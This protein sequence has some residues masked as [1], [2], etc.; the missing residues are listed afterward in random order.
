MAQRQR[1]GRVVFHDASLHVWE[2]GLGLCNGHHE[3]NEWERSFKREVFKR[4]IQQL[5]RMGWNA[6]PWDK[7]EQY[8]CIGDN[9]RTC[10]KGDLHGELALCGRHIEFN[11]WQSV[12]TPNRPDYG[13]RY[14]PNKEAVMPYVLRIRM[15]WT[16]RRLRDYLCNVFSG[17]TFDAKKS[18]AR[19]NKRG[20]NGLTAEEWV[21]ACYDDSYHNKG[22]TLTHCREVSPCNSRAAHGSTIQHGQRVWFA[23][24]KGRICTGIAYYNLNNMWLVVTGKY[25]VSNKAC[26]DLHTQCP[27]NPR[28]KR[29]ER[30]RRKR[31]EEELAKAVKSM[32]FERAARLRDIAFPPGETLFTAWSARNEAYHRPNCHGYATDKV[33]AGRFTRDELVRFS[34]DKDVVIQAVA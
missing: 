4:I 13:G 33:D 3:R 8:E 24:W 14:E 17:Y 9:H 15:E 22:M 5:N 21:Q 19:Q 6:G 29:N 23:D 26:F 32:N 34:G 25:N 30:L 1:E 2:E 11:M 20:P 12:N 18:D 16:R 10:R 31:L 7:A 27:E 28:V